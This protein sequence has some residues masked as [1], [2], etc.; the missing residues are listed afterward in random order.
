MFSEILCKTKLEQL[1]LYLHEKCI[2]MIFLNALLFFLFRW[3]DFL[4]CVSLKNTELYLP[5]KS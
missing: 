3:K 4:K 2:K 1:R 5:V